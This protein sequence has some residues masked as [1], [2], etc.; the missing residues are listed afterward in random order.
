M[1]DIA[2]PKRTS[3][4]GLDVS[5]QVV[6]GRTIAQRR[7]AVPPLQLSRVRYDDAADPQKAV[8]TLSH[9]GGVLEGDQYQVHIQA[10]P[11]ARAR[12]VSAAATAIHPALHHGAAQDVTISLAADSRFEWLLEPTILYA[13]ARFRQN[14]RIELAPGAGLTLMETIVPGRLARGECFSFECFENVLEVYEAT[15]KPH[16]TPRLLVSER[17]MIEPQ[18]QPLWKLPP[19]VKTPVIGSLYLLGFSMSTKELEDSLQ[20]NVSQLAG[21]TRLPNNAGILMRVI[22]NTASSVYGHMANLANISKFSLV[23]RAN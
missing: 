19:F 12:I 16:N 3:C 10:A 22:G 18:T 6:A 21:M 7:L 17:S 11:S 2:V 20:A 9:L 4:G 8:L 14:T 15:T 13:G 1:P 5:F 23:N